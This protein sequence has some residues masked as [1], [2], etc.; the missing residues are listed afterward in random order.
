MFSNK[1]LNDAVSPVV[2]V[3]LMVA[4]TVILAAVIGTFVLDLGEDVSANPQAGVSFD[5]AH[6][7]SVDV[8][9]DN[10]ED[11]DLY[12]VSVKVISMENADEVKVEHDGSDT[13]YYPDTTQT[14]EATS[15]ATVSKSGSPASDVG[16]DMTVSNLQEGDSV[17]VIGDL[18][19][20]SAVIQSYTVG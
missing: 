1:T 12:D 16:A 19:G 8:N 17:T 9:D 3:I 7:Q 5:Q 10:S 18:D 14:G 6:S 4:V 2:A 11:T 13:T 20:K 15:T